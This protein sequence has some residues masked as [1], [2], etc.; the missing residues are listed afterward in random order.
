MIKYRWLGLI[1]IATLILPLVIG[2]YW[3]HVA[4]EILILG[5]FAVSFNMIFGYMG[6]LVE[7]GIVEVTAVL[8]V[9]RHVGF[10]GGG[11][12]LLNADPH[13]PPQNNDRR[14]GSGRKH[15]S[16]G[17]G[18]VSI[19]LLEAAPRRGART[20]PWEVGEGVLSDRTVACGGLH[21]QARD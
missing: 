16:P 1:F 3:I 13:E 6:L 20:P 9:V 11:D 14:A 4:V 21:E 5:L 2:E 17:H 15:L 19:E 18:I 10:G 7:D 8:D 12:M